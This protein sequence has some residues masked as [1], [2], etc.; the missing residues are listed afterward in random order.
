MRARLRPAFAKA[1][2]GAAFRAT[3]TLTI[4]ARRGIS[5]ASRI[6]AK[7]SRKTPTQRL[8][9]LRKTCQTL[10]RATRAKQNPP[11]AIRDRRFS[12]FL[13]KL[14]LG[15]REPAYLQK[16]AVMRYPRYFKAPF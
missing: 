8:L 3:T 14:F 15:G 12:R 4:A 1:L 2:F 13:A 7:K 6:T 16:S 10:S 11:I 9:G 5:Q